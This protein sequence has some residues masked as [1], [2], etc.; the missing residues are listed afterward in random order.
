[1][2]PSSIDPSLVFA[3]QAAHSIARGSPAPVHDRGGYRVDTGSEHETRRWIFPRLGDGVREIGREVA[4][5]RHFMKVCVSDQAL[6][7]ALPPHWEVEPPGFFMTTAVASADTKPLP[8]GYRLELHHV[9]P[10]THV[11]IIAPD[12]EVAASGS[13]A[14]TSDVFIYDR[15]GTAQ[16]HRRKG[17]GLA[18]MAAL[19]TG[20]KSIA[21]Q[22]L[23]AATEDGRKL[24][25]T[26]GWTVLAP[27]ATAS[28]P[29]G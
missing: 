29:E 12:G 8:E 13:A 17:L 15:I 21:N 5:P 16:E 7:D 22:Q 6:R 4:A 27:L 1:M 18:V 14:E 11:S 24:Y 28:I 2:S 9:W 26:M 23:L 3:W 10:V 19:G 25:E 20:R